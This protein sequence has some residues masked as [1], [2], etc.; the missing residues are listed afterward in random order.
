MA[1]ATIG[2]GFL[3]EA[4]TNARS[5][6]TYS[7]FTCSSALGVA[8]RPVYDAVLIVLEMDSFTETEGL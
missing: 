4:C 2:F 5:A 1:D 8:C 7:H 6:A 3:D